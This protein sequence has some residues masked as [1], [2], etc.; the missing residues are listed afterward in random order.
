MRI[1]PQKGYKH[2]DSTVKLDLEKSSRSYMTTR[3]SFQKFKK[4]MSKKS[5]KLAT[6]N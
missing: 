2:T 4:K 3:L 5:E 1:N 6:Q